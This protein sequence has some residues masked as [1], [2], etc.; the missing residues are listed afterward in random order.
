MPPAYLRLDKVTRVLEGE[1]TPVRL[2]RHRFLEYVPNPRLHRRGSDGT[3]S[4]VELCIV[5]SGVVPQVSD[6]CFAQSRLVT[7]RNRAPTPQ[8]ADATREQPPEQHSDPAK[9][10]AAQLTAREPGVVTPFSA[11]APLSFTANEQECRDSND[12]G[13]PRF[14]D[15][16][17]AV[18]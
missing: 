1:P 4:R 2:G 5:L 10:S 14:L 8:P 15:P 9:S 18:A 17:G 16:G 3:V 13:F 6:D 7:Q 11:G 12:G